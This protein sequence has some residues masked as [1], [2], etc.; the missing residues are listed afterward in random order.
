MRLHDLFTIYYKLVSGLNAMGAYMAFCTNAL[1]MQM[2]N[3]CFEIRDSE[4]KR[5]W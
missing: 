2:S 5:M 1:Y 4:K 3:A